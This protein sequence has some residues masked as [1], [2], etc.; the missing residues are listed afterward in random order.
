VCGWI[1]LVAVML[2][3]V[4]ALA[5]QLFSI[6]MIQHELMMLVG[7]PLLIA[8]QPLATCLWGLPEAWRR[9][10][11]TLIATAPFRAA[12]RRTTLPV[13]AWALHGL[14]IWIWHIPRLYGA[15]VANEGVHA[16]QHAMFVFTA[17]LFW[18]G[19]IAGRYGRAGYGA[20]VFYVFT[21]VVH[22]GL[23]GAMLTFAPIPLYPIYAA[24]AAA[25]GIDPLTDQQAAGLLMWLPAGTILSVLGIALF[26]AW[27]GESARRDRQMTST[28]SD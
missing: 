26:A 1:T 10:S 11:G 8:S 3:P 20:A 5:I 28:A 19:L 16:L 23:L 25:L 4:D 14:V 15:A 9:K 22:T 12:W 17:A 7:A 2:P 24:P 18:W 21:T 6:H 13:V 27:L